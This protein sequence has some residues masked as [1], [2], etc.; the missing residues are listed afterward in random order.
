MSTASR[1]SSAKAEDRF[2]TWET[3]EAHQS[4]KE[5]LEMLVE[6]IAIHFERKEKAPNWK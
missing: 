1:P 2:Y 3:Y 4:A 5:S 6:I